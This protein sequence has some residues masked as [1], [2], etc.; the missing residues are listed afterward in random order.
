V[1][2]STQ[3]CGSGPCSFTVTNRDGSTSTYGTGTSGI[4]AVG[5]P[6]LRVWALARNVDLDGNAIDFAYTQSPVTGA[7]A[8]DG[9]YY[10]SSIDYSSNAAAGAA[11]NRS[12][13]FVYGPR[14]ATQLLSAYAGGSRIFTRAMLTNVRTFLSG[15]LV[16][17]YRIAYANSAATGR[18]LLQNV[19]RW[20]G[21]AAD[22]PRL[23]ATLLHWEGIAQPSMTAVDLG[24]KLAAPIRDILAFD[25]NGDGLGDLVTIHGTTTTFTVT[26]LVSTGTALTVCGSIDV[27][28]VQ[29]AQFVPV[30]L[31][32]N[33]RGDLVYL[34]AS[35]N[36][37]GYQIYNGQACGFQAGASGTLQNLP[38]NPAQLWPMDL[39]GDGFTD[40]VAALLS[41]GTYTV[42]AYLGSANGF[43][44]AETSELAQQPNERFWPADVNGD[45]MLDLVQGWYGSSGPVHLTAF[46]SDGR[47]LGAG[48]DTN[49]T[50]GPANLQTLYAEDVNGDGNSDVVHG[51]AAD[52]KLQLATY[53]A[54]GAGAFVCEQ[55]T[56]TG[57]TSQCAVTTGAGLTNV[58]A[59]WPMDVTGDSRV[60][61]VQA[62]Q[63]GTKLSLV[64]YRNAN[65]GFDAGIPLGT[66]LLS[67]DTSGV[68]ALDLNG[69]GKS[70]LVQAITSG[71]TV[72][73]AGYLSQGPAPDLA[74]TITNTAGG[75]TTLAY[76]P[77]SDRSVYTPG[78]GT[79]PASDAL[80]YVYRGAPSQA[81][82][83]KVRGGRMQLLARSVESNDPALNSSTY[84]YATTYAYAG[85]LVDAVNGR[86]WLGFRSHSSTDQQIGQRTTTLQNQ[87]FPKTGT[88]AEIRYECAGGVS[89]DPRCAATG[90]TLLT[91]SFTT[92]DTFER[93]SG[94]TAPS[95]KVYEVLKNT[96]RFDTYSYGTYEYSRAT[97]YAYDDYGNV[98]LLSDLGTVDRQGNDL[99]GDAVYTCSS[100][101]DTTGANTWQLGF[102]TARKVSA[103]A[104][105]FDFDA[106][107]ANV[108]FYLDKYSYTAQKN[109]ETH[110]R[111]DTTQ[112]AFLVTRYEY[113]GFGHVRA[114]TLPGNRTTTY[115]YEPTYNS[116][117]AT[118][119]LPPNDAGVQLVERTGF[120]PRFD[121]QVATATPAGNVAVQC[122]DAFGRVTTQQMPL[123]SEPAGVPAD[124]NCVSAEVTGDATRFRGAAV[125][126]ALTSTPQ[127]DAAKRILVESRQLEQWPTGPSRVTLATRTYSDGRGRDYL[128]TL[129]QAAGVSA[130]C[131]NYDSDDEVDRQSLPA[132]FTGDVPCTSSTGDASLLWSTQTR[133]VYRR[134]TRA[135]QPAGADG[136]QTTVT[137]MEYPTTL[138]VTVTRA[139]GEPEQ[140]VK[141][142][143]YAYYNSD[144]K[145]TKVIAPQQSNA[146]STFGYDLVGRMTSAVDPPTP[147][148][149]AGV[150]TI[151]TYDSLDRRTSVDNPD[152]NTC[153]GG[154]TGCVAGRKALTLAYDPATGLL[155]T[156]TDAKGLVTTYRFDKLAR[157]TARVLAAGEGSGQIRYTYD[158]SGSDFPNGPGQLTTVEQT[159][160]SN[161]R[162]FR[163]RYGY[164]RA[165][166]RNNVV[167]DLDGGAYTTHYVFDPVGRIGTERYPDGFTATNNYT[168][169]NL[170]AIASGTTTYARFSSFN[171]MQFP[172]QIVYGNGVTATLG[173]APTGQPTLQKLTD[174]AAATIY[175]VEVHWNRLF[176]V[177]GATDRLKSGGV[178]RSVSFG[179]TLTRLTSA[180]G[181]YGNLAFGYDASG[182]LTGKDG[183]TFTYRAHRP[184][185]ATGSGKPDLTLQ[186][187]SNGNLDTRQIGDDAWTY[188]YDVLNRLRSVEHGGSAVFQASIY[189]DNGRRLKKISADGT[190]ALYVS[191]HYELTKFPG[192][193]TETTK[194][195]G[196]PEGAVVSITTA[197]GTVTPGA[198]EPVVGTLYFHRDWIESTAVTTSAAGALS[199]RMAYVPY[200]GIYEPGVSGPDDFRLK[201]QQKELDEDIDLY[202]FDARYYDAATGRFITPD[203]Q[204]GS[205]LTDIDTLNRFAFALNNPATLIDPTGHAVWENIVGAL[206]GVA[207]IVLGVAIDVLSDGALEPLANVFISAGTNGLMYSATT[208]SSN[209]SWSQY[210]IQQAEG[211]LFGLIP[212]GNL[213]AG[214]T[215]TALAAAETAE[216]AATIGAREEAG[217]LAAESQGLALA[218]RSEA[219][220][221]AR[222]AELGAEDLA[223]EDIPCLAS[224]P[225]HTTV[226]TGAGA[227]PIAALGMGD[228]VLSRNF[229]D[230]TRSTQP[231]TYVRQR[232]TTDFVAMCLTGDGGSDDLVLTPNHP[233]FTQERGWVAARDVEAGE[234]VATAAGGWTG[235][236]SAS[237][238][239]SSTPVPVHTIEVGGLHS[240]FV[241]E[242]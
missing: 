139:A 110:S 22:S 123:P 230:A 153:F 236:T 77:M 209:F 144:R 107:T 72:T 125:V 233:L 169:G 166:N 100:Y 234:R 122:V 128:T 135:V 39:N 188:N 26:P 167:T 113:D 181:P 140:L 212:G 21:T 40:I 214:E 203:S 80:S 195:L 73:F 156:T 52:G 86:G 36:T 103:R 59:F 19:Q 131:T 147:A 189:D 229:I 114:E 64:L 157:N 42:A 106:F 202:Y 191:P 177:T 190:I 134:P 159:T 83:Q 241:G 105:C 145:L 164:D 130:I 37:F 34:F 112:S 194:Y 149:P 116:W 74:D 120:D 127:R 186:Y 44:F 11:N 207:E 111:Y 227:L 109:V 53:N 163:Y 197:D 104:Q 154:G 173:Y 142:L 4:A 101:D 180:T 47:K 68:R 201:F 219:R 187:D 50:A 18:P 48:I 75:K 3:L 182:N 27:P 16:S 78:S 185:S 31:S 8:A 97:R 61:L 115:A 55:A 30:Q 200:G 38:P 151:V 168:Y 218:A 225:A 17:D 12:V 217:A 237:A 66:D 239:Q 242:Q 179:Y 7:T 13:R 199:T 29:Q 240:Y 152:Q 91:D 5:R 58:A 137:T 108:D 175:D 211:A 158:E 184:T 23:P 28:V 174:A 96:V 215:R 155:V 76:L 220:L 221:S 176:N 171:A 138:R 67:T 183:Y 87:E 88:T 165:A 124:V 94:A 49:V 170:T 148:N 79:A 231:V 24:P 56:A 143:E 57:V 118:T 129:E 89:P 9:E 90:T 95:P 2:A 25:V 85:A 54:S 60:D 193:G 208:S 222:E 71:T 43:T 65:T 117:L 93:A 69:D 10:L 14:P 63:N 228:G 178:D 6:D 213:I 82:F 216:R 102:V 141:T 232:E 204:L 41:Q 81:P 172:Q 198:G 192:A 133:D 1:V 224:F 99:G 161:D 119:T 235:V 46:V 226:W 33:G 35:G 160:T 84:S 223:K 15:Q 150:P 121:V 238:F 32:T 162:V 126:T 98:T 45:G 196:T 51:W 70:D 92:Y 62:W 205:D 136:G 132:L 20:A 210:G 206:V 146:T